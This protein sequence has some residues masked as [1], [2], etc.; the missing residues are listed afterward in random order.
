MKIKGRIADRAIAICKEYLSSPCQRANLKRGEI[1]F[2][3]NE[4]AIEMVI[5][6]IRITNSGDYFTDRTVFRRE[7]LMEINMII[8]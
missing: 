2:N 1:L 5:N 3:Q 7:Q 6:I 4:T 8:K